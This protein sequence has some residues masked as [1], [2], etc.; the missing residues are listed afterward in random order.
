M[1]LKMIK[2]IKFVGI[3]S[4]IFISSACSKID[5]GDIVQF[6]ILEQ[7]PNLPGTP[8]NYSNIA[9]PIHFSVIDTIASDVVVHTPFDKDNTLPNNKI[10]DEG[11][12]LGRVLFYDK[13]LSQN[14]TISCSSCHI[15]SL[16]FTDDRPLSE[17]FDGGFTRRHSQRIA[18]ARFYGGGKSFW[19]ER[20]ESIEDQV[21]QPIQDPVEMGLTLEEAV[22]K[23]KQQNF[24]GP[25]FKDA[26]G[27]ENITSDRIS[28]ALAQFVRS[29]VSYQS[30][31][32][33]GREQVNTIVDNFPNFTNQENLGKRIFMSKRGNTDASC[34]TCHYTETFT[35]E[36]PTN[37]GLDAVSAD[38]KGVFE[39]TNNIDDLGKFK[40]SSLRNIAVTGPYMRDGRFQT[41][42]EVI[43]F[44]SNEIQAHENLD[45][46]LHDKNGM[47]FRFNF[48][49]SQ[50]Q[51]LLAFLNTLTDY[52][53]LK[54]IKYSDP[55]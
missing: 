32:D 36:F 54:D 47:P 52:E 10:T 11:A 37:N 1:K 26:F 8:F 38:D 39:T 6:E 13:N 43:N 18:N 14:N 50:R 31:Y 21:L 30:K 7:T 33:E 4:L 24:Y 15:Q 9:F 23:I 17:G 3:A 49:Q 28:K 34:I 20:A 46:D 22:A 53:L 48:S 12:T 35:S 29:I 5:S 16:G 40:V 2:I 27:T 45:T 55:F 25:L 41:L 51:A 42:S 19:D 44:Y